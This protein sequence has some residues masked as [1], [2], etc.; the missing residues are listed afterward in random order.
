MVPSNLLVRLSERGVLP[1][2][3]V[4][5]SLIC[6]AIDFVSGPVIQFPI[7]YL[8]PISLA[9]WYGGRSW[10]VALAF[11]LPLFRLYFRNIW[12]PPWTLFESSINAA[13]RVTVF[14]AFAWL[15]DRAARQMRDL[16]RMRLLEGI[17]GLCS[18]CKKIR[19]QQADAWR[20]L[21]VYV[22]DHVREFRPDLCPDCSKQVREVFDRR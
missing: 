13:I 3:W 14:V 1:I 9:A 18:V 12:D 5:L 11:L 21:D 16:R 19:D 4:T 8:A 7:V 6:L 17:L 22:A 20:P 10:G 2:Y 15:V